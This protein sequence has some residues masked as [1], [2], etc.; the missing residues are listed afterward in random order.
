MAEDNKKHQVVD[1]V[2]DKLED[3]ATDLIEKA[4]TSPQPW[5]KKALLYVLAILL[6]G[7]AFICT[8]YGDQI[9][10]LIEELLKNLI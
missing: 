6:G 1:T 4:N 7:G 9:Y 2:K 3:V 5:Y 8:N 10:K